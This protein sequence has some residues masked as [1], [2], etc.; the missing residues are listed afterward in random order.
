MS[1]DRLRDPNSTDRYNATVEA[2]QLEITEL[3]A[4]LAS[5][6]DTIGNLTR[7]LTFLRR[8]PPA[9]PIR[10]RSRAVAA[11]PLDRSTLA[12]EVGPTMPSKMGPQ[13]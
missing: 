2:L 6:Y 12:T 9:A 11:P 5:T 10:A 3:H 1:D 8:N 4:E 7:S 13:T